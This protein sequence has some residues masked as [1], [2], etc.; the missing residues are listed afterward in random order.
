MATTQATYNHGRS[1]KQTPPP[2]ALYRN[3]WEGPSSPLYKSI[4]ACLQEALGGVLSEERKRLGLVPE[5]FAQLAHFPVSAIKAFEKCERQP[6]LA[7][8]ITLA[9]S[10]DQ[11]PRE[12]LDKLLLRMGLPLGSRPVLHR[13]RRRSYDIA[14]APTGG[15]E[16]SP[17]SVHEPGPQ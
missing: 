15:M 5:S 12:L 7:A 14:A 1:T 17:C 6:K 16:N 13:S 8:F 10:C 2:P 11:D 9:W 3:V 4:T